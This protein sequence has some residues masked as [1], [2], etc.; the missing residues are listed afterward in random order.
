MFPL[1]VAGL[2]GHRDELSPALLGTE[3]RATTSTAAEERLARLK[4][5]RVRLEEAPPL[6]ARHEIEKIRRGTV[7]GRHP[8]PTPVDARPDRL[9]AFRRR[10]LPRIDDRSSLRIDLLR[11]R[12][13]HERFRAEEFAGRAIEHVVEAVA[14]RH[15][16]ELSSADAIDQDRNLRGVPVTRVVRRELKMPLHC[17]CIGIHG[18]Q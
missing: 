6:L 2:R 4:L 17:P 11:P 9:V 13:L 12:L 1:D 8:V 14:A 7:T 10:F 16:H 18:K 15:D 5:R 3:P